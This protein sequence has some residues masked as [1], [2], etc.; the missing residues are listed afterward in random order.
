[1]A[2]GAAAGGGLAGAAVTSSMLTGAGAC[3]TM[4]AVLEAGTEIITN[5]DHSIHMG[6]IITSGIG[7]TIGGLVTG[8]G[9]G[10]AAS[11]AINTTTSATVSIVNDVQKGESASK[12]V[13]DAILNA[14]FGA[15]AGFRGG[16]GATKGAYNV[17]E[18]KYLF[19]SEGK[20]VLGVTSKINILGEF[21]DGA[22]IIERALVRG[23]KTA[24]KMTFFGCPIMTFFTNLYDGKHEEVCGE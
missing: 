1:M 13:F 10:K 15:Y 6:Q 4:S 8:S 12:I 17:S 20:Y 23:L 11:I 18:Y 19:E 16:A 22:E 7:G 5:P 24:A 9:L 14:G 2:A 21:G 3:G